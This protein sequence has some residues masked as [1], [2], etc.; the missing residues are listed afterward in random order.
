MDV[1]PTC[2]KKIVD[3]HKLLKLSSPDD[4]PPLPSVPKELRETYVRLVHFFGL[5]DPLHLDMTD[6]GFSLDSTIL[7]AGTDT[8]STLASAEMKQR[9]CEWLCAADP[10]DPSVPC[11]PKAEL[12][13]RASSQGWA[14]SAFNATI[15]NNGPT[16]VLI[17]SDT[18][19]I[20]GGYAALPWN[21]N[22]L[23]M[24]APESFSPCIAPPAYRR[25]ACP[26]SQQTSRKRST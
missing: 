15:R 20:F 19:H 16:L 21:S 6:R 5:S 12:L 10:A 13:Y 24:A 23:W 17:K 2:F 11:V 26:S 9:L 1:N 4:P 18:G 14:V 8:A 7:S 22:G 3:F 25:P